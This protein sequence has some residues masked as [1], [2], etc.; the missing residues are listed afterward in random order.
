MEALFK[1]QGSTGELV[2]NFRN[3]TNKSILLDKYRQKFEEQHGK[4]LRFDEDYAEDLSKPY[5]EQGTHEKLEFYIQMHLGSYMSRYSSLKHQMKQILLLLVQ[6]YLSSYKEDQQ[7]TYIKLPRI[8][9]PSFSGDFNT[10]T[11]F[12]DLCQSLVMSNSSESDVE[13]LHHLKSSLTNDATNLCA[14][15]LFRVITLP[16]PGL[17]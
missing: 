12:H 10:W 2:N 4:I 1:K 11:I 7:H 8:T 5:F 15:M 6:N 17:F 3:N 16:L 13:R 9:I 14:S